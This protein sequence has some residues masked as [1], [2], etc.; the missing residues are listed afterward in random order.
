LALRQAV[1][2]EVVE[3]AVAGAEAMVGGVGLAEGVADEN[4]DDLLVAPAVG[5]EALG[6]ERQVVVGAGLAE[7][8]AGIGCDRQVADPVG[9]MLVDQR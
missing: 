2:Q 9:R 1:E 3:V 8:G 5:A 7:G 6:D 4:R